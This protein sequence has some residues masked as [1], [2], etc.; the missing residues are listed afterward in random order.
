[1]A[2]AP[3]V[4]IYLKWSERS[5]TFVRDDHSD[6]VIEAGRFPLVISTVVEGVKMTRVLMDGDNV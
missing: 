5:I 1:M 3:V 4:P 2:A 6:H